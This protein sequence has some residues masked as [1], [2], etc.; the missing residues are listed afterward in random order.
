MNIQR[1]DLFKM[2]L[3]TL[4]TFG[5]Y[6]IYWTFKTKDMLVSFGGDIPTAILSLLPFINIYF[7]YKYSLAFAKYVGKTDKY[8]K[9]FVLNVFLPVISMFILQD[10]INKSSKA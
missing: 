3:L 9:Y 1:R 7:W 4:V 10:E 2:A 5:F 8:L 6:Y